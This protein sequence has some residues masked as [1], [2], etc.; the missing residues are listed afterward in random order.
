MRESIKSP[1]RGGMRR[2][3]SSLGKDQGNNQSQILA[4]ELG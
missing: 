2:R 3:A 1:D 4:E